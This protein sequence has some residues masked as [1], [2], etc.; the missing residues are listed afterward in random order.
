V[1]TAKKDTHRPGQAPALGL[2]ACGDGFSNLSQTD[3][4]VAMRMRFLLALAASALIAGG[5]SLRAGGH[6]LPATARPSAYSLDDMAADMALFSTSGN[7]LDYYPNT[8]FQILYVSDTN[9]FTVP[10]GTRFFVPVFFVDDSPPVLGNF[11]I[12]TQAIADYVFGADQL[13]GYDMQIV[14]DGRSTTLGPAYLGSAYVGGTGLLDGGGH[15]FIQ[16]GGFLTPLPP[17]EHTVSI[18]ANFD[19][20]VIV[21]LFGSGI[22]LEASYTVIVED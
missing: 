12:D 11:P 2:R 5:A 13:G 4:E 18:I 8:P 19:G 16:L 10:A 1:P 6:V 7:D 14:V 3:E 20:E 15:I 17:G 22:T 9:T 21:G